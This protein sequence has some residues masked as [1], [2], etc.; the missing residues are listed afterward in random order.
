MFHHRAINIVRGDAW[1]MTASTLGSTEYLIDLVRNNANHI[2]ARCTCHE[3]AGRELCRHI[4]AALLLAEKKDLL[5]GP[6]GRPHKVTLSA[7][8]SSIVFPQKEQGRRPGRWT[9]RPRGWRTI[10]R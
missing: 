8:F 3:F 9:R 6:G 10:G 4:W 5:T 1:A 2:T 7:D